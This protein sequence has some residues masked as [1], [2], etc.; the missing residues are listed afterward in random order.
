MVRP[1]HDENWKQTPP[2]DIDDHEEKTIK[3]SQEFNPTRII[4]VDLI[5]SLLFDLCVGGAR[6]LIKNCEKIIERYYRFSRESR[7]SRVAGRIQYLTNRLKETT[8]H[9][10]V[11]S[12]GLLN[13]VTSQ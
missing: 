1:L 11:C 9:F 2:G 13:E 4:F 7:E 10:T 12:S 6:G 8:D 3:P 5:H